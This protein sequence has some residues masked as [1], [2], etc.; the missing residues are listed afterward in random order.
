M[1]FKFKDGTSNCTLRTWME[2]GDLGFDENSKNMLRNHRALC[3]DNDT[4]I[5]FS[6][7]PKYVERALK[8]KTLIKS[9]HVVSQWW[10][11]STSDRIEVTT[12]AKMIFPSLRKLAE[13]K[14]LYEG[15]FANDED[16]V[17]T[18][19]PPTLRFDDSMVKKIAK[20]EVDLTKAV[21]QTDFMSPKEQARWLRDQNEAALYGNNVDEKTKL[22]LMDTYD[23]K[24]NR[25]QEKIR[26]AHVDFTQS[27]DE[28]SNSQSNDKDYDDIWIAQR[29]FKKN[30]FRKVRNP[31]R[32]WIRCALTN[33]SGVSAFSSQG[34][35]LRMHVKT[36]MLKLTVRI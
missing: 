23:E 18:L 15:K 6:T 3:Y 27:S 33:G 28:S 7:F 32:R 2:E 4:K 19:I 24:A 25:I 14:E 10:K 8:K 13:Q 29:H 5:V 22:I 35:S 1:S 34:V 26:T 11:A 20:G 12:I 16:Y 17:Y 9:H 21:Q 30:E 31:G 36:E